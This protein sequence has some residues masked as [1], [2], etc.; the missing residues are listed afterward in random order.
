MSV[1]PSLSYSTYL[2]TG[3]NRANAVTMDSSGDAFVVE[4]PP[5]TLYPVTPGAFIKQQR[6]RGPGFRNKTKPHWYCPGLLHFPRRVEF[7]YYVS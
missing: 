6:G 1:A 7:E 5:P 2:G 3:G 4:D